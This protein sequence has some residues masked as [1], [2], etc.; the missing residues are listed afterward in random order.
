ML[1]QM[2]SGL[3]LSRL[4]EENS[5]NRRSRRRISSARYGKAVGITVSMAAEIR[6]VRKRGGR[7]RGHM[8]AVTGQLLLASYAIN[9]REHGNWSLWDQIGPVLVAYSAHS[10]LVLF[11][12]CGL[13]GCLL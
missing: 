4:V 5:S 8:W 11:I 10:S 7:D 3:S 1:A 13:L 12:S 6:R 9:D 2:G